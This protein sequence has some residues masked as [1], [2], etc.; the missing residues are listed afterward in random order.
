MQHLIS[1]SKVWLQQLP[2]INYIQL[3]P[4]EEETFF[5]SLRGPREEVINMLE[6]PLGQMQWAKKSAEGFSHARERFI[7]IRGKGLP[8]SGQ[9][10]IG[11]A[12]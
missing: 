4:L 11:L 6:N 9:L 8:D 5:I 7:L 3:E 10:H 1:H 12:L 2:Q